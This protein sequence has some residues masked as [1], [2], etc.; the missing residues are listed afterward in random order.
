MLVTGVAGLETWCQQVTFGY[1]GVDVTN[2]TESWRDGLAFCV[3]IHRFRPHLIDISALKPGISQIQKNCQLAF[4]I[5]EKELDIPALLD[6]RDMLESR[7]LD[8][9]SILTYLS[10]FY[11][12]FAKEP[13]VGAPVFKANNVKNKTTSE[14]KLPVARSVSTPIFSLNLIQQESVP[15]EDKAELSNKIETNNSLPCTLNSSNKNTVSNWSSSGQCYSNKDD[16]TNTNIK[17]RVETLIETGEGC[18]FNHEAVLDKTKTNDKIY[19]TNKSSTSQNIDAIKS[20]VFDNNQ[21]ESSKSS[22]SSVMTSK[23]SSSG[24]RESDSGLGQSSESSSS[25]SSSTSSSRLSSVSPSFNNKTKN[26]NQDISDT[27][28]DNKTLMF[29][30]QGA[31]LIIKPKRS[32]IITNN[33][34][35]SHQSNK[36][37]QGKRSMNKSFQEAII[38][39][40]SLSMQ[41]E[42]DTES[43]DLANY[44]QNISLPVKNNNNKHLKSQSSQ[45]D[46]DFIQAPRHEKCTPSKSQNLVSQQCQT[47]ESHLSVSY[48]ETKS[49]SNGG[50]K[51]SHAAKTPIKG[52]VMSAKVQ[53]PESQ[54][55]YNIPASRSQYSQSNGSQP[56]G[57]LRS[58]MTR[59]GHRQPRS[60]RPVT[61]LG[62]TAYANI[63]ADFNHQNDYYNRN[64]NYFASQSG[65]YST[66]V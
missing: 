26:I 48:N 9:R 52:S 3:V 7:K 44:C 4:S 33:R 32:H 64:H 53:G 15:N 24:G 30:K 35:N 25:S 49:M 16:C 6:I 20:L 50:H 57:Q 11:H 40:N 17:T 13:I 22:S 51:L 8:K 18:S 34:I 65:V 66:L 59:T 47:E 5:A 36:H 56:G 58:R 38:K 43:G 10:Q 21:P 31:N 46:P 54:N 55:F 1:P 28:F 42:N 41:T 37:S 61:S 63:V 27:N 45:T 29:R 39:F 19:S 60:K 23:N 14:T 12:K 62:I 2:M